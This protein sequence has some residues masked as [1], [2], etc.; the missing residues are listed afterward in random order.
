MAENGGAT[1]DH[2]PETRDCASPGQGAPAED[3]AQR[4]SASEIMAERGGESSNSEIQGRDRGPG[5]Q[6]APPEGLWPARQIV[7]ETKGFEPSKR[8]NPLTPLAGE[9][10]R[11]LGHVS[12]AENVDIPGRMQAP[13][14]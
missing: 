12:A 1:F 3:I 4:L 13:I 14:F 6:P 2:A 7:A 10:L 9:R 8:F 11:P 5:G